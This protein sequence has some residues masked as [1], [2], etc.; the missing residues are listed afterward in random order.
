M[1]ETWTL[2][3][4]QVSKVFIARFEIRDLNSRPGG[5]LL[6]KKPSA[7]TS[8]KFFQPQTR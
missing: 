8:G 5:G 6:G 3:K 7:D 2:K 1:L 4:N